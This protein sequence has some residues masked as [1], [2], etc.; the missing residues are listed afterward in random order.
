[1]FMLPPTCSFETLVSFYETIQR[2][3]PD[4]SLDLYNI[5]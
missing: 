3:N 1:M 2:R 5:P 4:R